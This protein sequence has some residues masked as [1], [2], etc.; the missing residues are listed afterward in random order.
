M[1]CRTGESFLIFLAPRWK[2]VLNP[3]CAK[4]SLK[5]SCCLEFSFK[6]FEVATLMGKNGDKRRGDYE[7][8]R[9][10]VVKIK[11]I[12]VLLIV[13]Q[14][15]HCNPFNLFAKGYQKCWPDS[16]WENIKTI[17]HSTYELVHPFVHPQCLKSDNTH[18][19]WPF[20]HAPIKLACVG[21]EWPRAQGTINS[22]QLEA[23]SNLACC[24]CRN[25]KTC[26]AFHFHKNKT[27]PKVQNERLFF[28]TVV[29]PR[30]TLRT[31][32]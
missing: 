23:F 24:H 3:C 5:E 32:W 20:M 11:G 10:G 6:S 25:A 15:Q 21:W 26:Q 1:D 27:A 31:P 28:I 16:N 12:P 19:H 8:G 29:Y 18:A 13:D 4:G 7:K 17:K 22:S 30:H 14:Y 9:G 2:L